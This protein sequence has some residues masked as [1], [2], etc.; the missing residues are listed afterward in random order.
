[1]AGSVSVLAVIYVLEIFNPLQ[2]GLLVGLSGALF[3]LPPLIWFY[4][5]QSVNER[6]VT[7]ALQIVIVLGL[8]TS[9]YG[10]YQ[11][12]AGYPAFKQ[13]WI[14]NTE[15]SESFGVGHVKRAL[16]TF[17]SAGEW[18]RYAELGAIAAFGFLAGAKRLRTRAG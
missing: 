3:M 11:L 17:S 13:Y 15:F 7:R 9:L 16:A 14:G 10:L 4:F 5:G 2:G 12:L 6:F 18:G 8:L 1:M